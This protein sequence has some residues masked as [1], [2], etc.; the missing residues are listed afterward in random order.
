MKFKTAILMGVV[1][2]LALLDSP[3]RPAAQE[4][5]QQAERAGHPDTGANPVPFINQPL[6]PDAVAPGG[7]GF[8]LTVNG[9]GFVS[10]S[11]VNWN[12]SPLATTFVSGS[13]LTAVVAA[14]E[15]ANASTASVT[16]VN[17][18]PGGGKSNVAFFT[19]TANVGNSIAFSLASSPA[20]GNA[21]SS[22]AVGDFNGDGKLD[23]AVANY[24][25]NTLSI[26][27]GDGTGN[28]TLASSPAT[29]VG[30]YSVAVGDFNGDG[31]LDLAVANT[32]SNT[33]SI[34]LG[35]GTGNFTLASSSA[36][37]GTA[38]SVAVG[39]FNGDG[40]LDLA[41][42]NNGSNTASILLGDGTGNFS[43]ASS[44]AMES[45]AY[46]VAVGDFNS[47][48]NLDL[49]FANSSVN[50]VS[51]LLGDGTG[52]FT[53][54]SSPAT[55]VTPISV[56][57]GDFNG[58][59]KLDLV[60]ANFLDVGV[61]ILL[62]DGT[63]N[64]SLTFSPQ[65][66][67]APQSVAVGDF[68]GDGKLDLAVANGGDST[69]SI[70]LGD[71]TG[72]FALTSSPGTGADPQSV[73]IGDFNGDGKLDLAVANYG[74]NTVSVLLQVP[75]PAVTLSPTS[76][77]F[78]TQ[79]VGTASALQTVTL[80]NTGGATLDITSIVASRYFR[81]VNTCESSLA[82]GATCNIRV[83]FRPTGP[84]TDTGTL[85]ITDNAPGSPQTVSLT[86][87]GTAVTLSPT[88]LNFG[89]QA[90]GTTSSAQ[91]VTF[92]N[93]ADRTLKISGVRFTGGDASDFAQTNTCGSSVTA[94]SSCTFS[95]TFT[96]GAT[97][98]RT[99]TLQIGD[100]GGGGG[101][102]VA[103]SGTGT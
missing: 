41:V 30:P 72:N 27:L 79:L 77:N 23:L 73:G 13:Q 61:S 50:T 85:T 69:V 96:S 32:G 38:I 46:S 35:D 22:V 25:S 58:D 81:E 86:G 93:H 36:T 82:A 75:P 98:S 80:S 20:T 24:T 56:A 102:T 57:V 59:G 42:A 40:K 53:L 90:V 4:Q 15:V 3:I 6:V 45:S 64:F 10:G 48:G 51:I 17:P 14:A 28:F 37:G 78:G 70:L 2:L 11:V 60:T 1:T 29:D 101:Q 84:G 26:L 66:G 33:V 97:G 65:T 88:S 52:N 9:T 95:V 43:L 67:S 100:N 21:P 39:D 91:T 83:N 94:G 12:G 34:L 87:F 54:A 8:T 44:P 62:G 92:T 71:G 7:A 89:N 16:V 76:L 49:A 5:R 31:R 74:S 63:G 103:L 68:N 18:A 99:A 19:V 55:G 47:D